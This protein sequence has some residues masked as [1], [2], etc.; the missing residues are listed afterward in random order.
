MKWIS[1][2]TGWNKIRVIFFEICWVI[3]KT[4][5]SFWFVLKQISMIN[6]IKSQ[7]IFDSCDHG[8][9]ISSFKKTKQNATLCKMIIRLLVLKMTGTEGVENII[10]PNTLK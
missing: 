5:D 4:E 2:V 7:W 6:D 1:K 10:Y 8:I 9:T 3:K